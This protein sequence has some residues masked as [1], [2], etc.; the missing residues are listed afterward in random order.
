LKKKIF[1]GED[2]VVHA[3]LIR[4]VLELLEDCESFFFPDGLEVYQQ[5]QRE[6]PDLLI[7]DII[8]PRLSGLAVTRLLKYHD[9]FRHIPILVT[10]SITDGNIRERAAKAGATVFV[11][12]PFEI[13]EFAETVRGLLAASDISAVTTNLAG[14]SAK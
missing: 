3:E 5:V 14:L 11:P 6:K 8:M 1:V 13:D 12:K 7:L 4:I 9:Q 10:S 2:N